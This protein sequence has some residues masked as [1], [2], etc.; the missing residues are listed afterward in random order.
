MNYYKKYLKYKNKYLQLQLELKQ[1]Q[2]GGDKAVIT[3]KDFINLFSKDCEE[4]TMLNPIY[5]LILCNNGFITNNYYLKEFINKN[6]NSLQEDI[7]TNVIIC[8]IVKEESIGLIKPTNDIMQKITPKCFGRFIA[9]KYLH[10]KKKIT[11]NISENG[12]IT[13]DNIISANSELNKKMNTYIN[14][15]KKFIPINEKHEERYFHIILYCL[16]WKANNDEGI[17]NYYEGIDEVFQMLE[18]HIAPFSL[19]YNRSD[20]P[21]N[22]FEKIVFEI[23]DKFVIFGQ[24]KSKHYCASSGS[25]EYPDCGETTAR[26]LINLICFNNDTFDLQLL[27]NFGAIEPVIEFYAKFYNF[28]EQS[29][30]NA[31]NEWSKLIIENA[32]KDVVFVEKCLET[33]NGYNL[34]SGLN[35]NETKD[36]F[37]Q[38][39]KNLLSNIEE[40]NDLKNELITNL[41]NNTRN[42]IGTIII[43]T[44][45]S[46]KFTIYLLKKHYYIKQNDKIVL[47]TYDFNGLSNSQINRINQLLIKGEPTNENYIDF[48]YDSEY[49]IELF[50]RTNN[51]EL[52]KKLFKLSFTRKYNDDIRS[53]IMID[54]DDLEFFNYIL[55]LEFTIS[56]KNI[57]C[58]NNETINDYLYKSKDFS[59]LAKI[60]NLNHLSIIINN[61]YLTYINTSFLINIISVDN[62]MFGCFKLIAI[63][64]SE[65]ENLKIIKNGFMNNCNEL[66][67]IKLPNNI[68]FIG[69]FFMKDCFKLITIDLS[70]LLNLES[71]RDYFMNDCSELITIY[72]PLN[73]KSIGNR[74]MNNCSK[75]TNI[76]LPLNTSSIGNYFMNNCSKLI[77]IDLP[78]NIELIGEYFINECVELTTIDLSAL[79]NLKKIEKYFMS[80]CSNL[81]DIELPNNIQS[82][83]DNFL[84]NCSNLTKIDLS[85][86]TNLESIGNNFMYNCC[87]L[88]DCELPTSIRSIDCYFMYDCREL[89]FIDLSSLINL[90]EIDNDFMCYCY[91]LTNIKL[92]TSIRTIGSKFMNNCLELTF[93]DL[94][95][96]INLE[97]IDHD[98]MCNCYKLTNIKLPTSIQTIGGN[99]MNECSELTTIDL[100][101][102]TKL[103]RIGDDFMF[104]CSNLINIKFPN[105]IESIGINCLKSTKTDLPDELQKLIN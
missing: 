73:I 21:N 94:S 79:T 29:S 93:I 96:L 22:V 35:A 87:K 70:H 38:L 37:L 13:Y 95:S 31:R 74:F 61:T 10:F 75:L 25:D 52:K 78:N 44:N 43:H 32:Q 11:I 64:L 59:F 92:P 27:H 82:I 91:K 71:I 33:N 24:E 19:N 17:K 76:K 51:I 99:F 67:D 12:N 18:F 102:L 15:F 16:W 69:R 2:S 57:K 56:K 97:E 8:K 26:N 14:V 98:F 60:P 28:A 30:V 3:N 48:N 88:T 89:T 41:E 9:I 39:I 36:N 101:T 53:Q 50:Q 58:I 45:E 20:E 54:V 83:D 7:D 40:W 90:E 72:F 42:G 104:N 100:S 81:T 46:K 47:D 68:E 23:T 1:K 85:L 63:D 84:L 62:F 80:E 5:G 49:L 4:E 6:N 66:K 103:E 65:L 105:N 86:L 34:Y 55:N 77:N